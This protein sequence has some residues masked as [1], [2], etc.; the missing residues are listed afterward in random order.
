M[1]KSQ[2]L[3]TQKTP[4]DDMA[5]V[6]IIRYLISNA[7][8]AKSTGVNI[9]IKNVTFKGTPGMWVFVPNYQDKNGVIVSTKLQNAV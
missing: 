9:D 4:F 3:T 8:T 5:E 7:L 6:D 2:N 1:S